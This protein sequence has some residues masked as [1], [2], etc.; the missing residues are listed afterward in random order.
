MSTLAELKALLERHGLRPRRR[1][2][3]NFLIDANFAAAVAREI[4]P[5]ECCV[6]LEVGPGTGVLTAALLAA[7]PRA[8]VLAVEL[9]PGLA[10]VLRE[11]LGAEMAAG[12]L[13]LLEGDA[14]EGKH[15]LN[16]AMVQELAR[17]SRD[18]SRPR[19]ILGA[20]LP[21]NAAT[22]LIANLALGE[23]V[24]R[25][26]ATIQLELAE[27]LVA[28]PNTPDY[29]PLSA[30]LA[31]RGHARMLRK[32]GPEVFWPRPQVHSAVVE[33]RLPP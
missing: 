12:R 5:D 9:D 24:D 3:Q 6:V 13:T 22:P 21:Y 10:G 27:R 26:V 7:H 2:G 29:G 14:L 11:A 23:T 20:N 16:P 1:L 17:I 32:I 8:R 28:K 31:L 4:A 33:V 25:I 15:G 18:E 30:F 19:R